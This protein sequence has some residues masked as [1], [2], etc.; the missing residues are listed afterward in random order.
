[1][2]RVPENR[3]GVEILGRIEPQ[4][5]LLLPVALPLSVHICVQCV[6]ISSEI[7]KELVVYLVMH[8]SLG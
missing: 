1:M 7:P 8:N 4:M 5:K 3:I 2:F 6:R